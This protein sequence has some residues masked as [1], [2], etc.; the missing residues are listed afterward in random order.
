MSFK[1]TL[2]LFLIFAS[3]GTYFYLVEIK[4]VEKTKEIEQEEKKVFSPIQKEEISEVIIKKNEI[5][6]I[7]R[8]VKENN[9]WMI[10]EPIKADVDEENVHLFID[11]IAR[12]EKDRIVVNSSENQAEYGLE[13]PILTLQIKANKSDPKTLLIGDE[14]ST[15]NMFY[16]KLKKQGP[17]F[18]IAS[19]N[20]TGIEKTLYELR[21]KRIFHFEND[22]IKEIKVASGKGN[23]SIVKK[24]KEWRI[25]TPKKALADAN[26]IT[27]LLQK[28]KTSKIKKFIDEEADDL[29]PYGL[30]DPDTQITLLIGK[31]NAP[32]VLNIG[33]ENA[34]ENG[35][36]A[37]NDFK[38]TVFLLEKEFLREFP[39]FLT[40]VRDKSILRFDKNKVAQIQWIYP[41]RTITTIRENENWKIIEPKKA[42]ADSLEINSLLDEI[43][44]TEVVEFIS[45][46]GQNETFALDNPRLTVKV[47]EKDISN[48]KFISF[49]SDNPNGDTV[50]VNTGASDEVF[51]VGKEFL[52]KL[53]LSE[54]SLRY[55]NLLEIKE[56]QVAGIQIKA[57]GDEYIL[58][59]NKD[60]WSLEKPKKKKLDVLDAKRI[61]WDLG[62]IKFKEIIDESGNP[63]LGLYGLE[64]PLIKVSLLD[65]K[66]NNLDTLFI[67]SKEK[68][69]NK[70]YAR[71]SKT[72]TIYSVE[73]KV[74]DDLLNNIQKL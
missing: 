33:K 12:L 11:N 43:E 44:E 2:L 10:K 66:Q 32:H 57:E 61:L 30:N 8:L 21:D 71:T 60:E 9:K 27:S 20:K 34:E 70:L 40:D 67:G 35:I 74:K 68:N 17:I 36:Y 50:Y 13:N 31:D 46:E 48:P 26:K 42:K 41:D 24:E 58:T 39:Y 1:K 5:N 3:I 16:G 45:K 52:A 49:G 73:L 7:T 47:F 55:K 28:I 54:L 14:S 25:L 37:K 69:N 22:D 23:Y 51:L 59:K 63:N 15:G 65:D 72:K 19:Y 6:K 18:F 38:N 4:K 53:S 56:E 62:S 64:K 29:I